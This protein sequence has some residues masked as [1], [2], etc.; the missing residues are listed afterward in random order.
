MLSNPGVGGAHAFHLQYRRAT[1]PASTEEVTTAVS[2]IER[3]REVVE[4]LLEEHGVGLYD[5]E[6]AGTQL[7]I[8]VETS[9]LEAIERL[10][11][12]I[13]RGL[14]EADPITSRYTLEVSSPGLERTLRI[15]AHFAGAIGT[16]VKVK[17][18]P[19]VEGDRR[20]EGVLTRA[21]D[22][23]ITVGDRTLRYEEIERARTVFEWGSAAR[24]K[25]AKVS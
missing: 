18:K 23:G 2:T 9:D 12:A 22:E 20:V 21:D 4:P 3:V 25:K 15:P 14:D 1:G 19:D 6:L 16:A 5:L 7:R 17:T 11:R 8:T 10:T 13:S 24:P